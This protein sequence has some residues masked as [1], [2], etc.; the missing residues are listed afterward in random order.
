MKNNKFFFMIVIVISIFICAIGIV[1]DIEK[2]KKENY[3]VED[4]IENTTIKELNYGFDEY[5]TLYEKSIKKIDDGIGGWVAEEVL[6]E[7]KDKHKDIDN[8]NVKDDDKEKQYYL[9]NA[10]KFLEQSLI[11][12]DQ[13]V[14]IEDSVRRNETLS[15]YNKCLNTSKACFSEY[16]NLIEN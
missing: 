6:S 9:S 7:I 13:S 10:Y 14:D 2:Q 5:A 15:F 12:F 3:I 8:M 16:E 11:L 1:L 4:S